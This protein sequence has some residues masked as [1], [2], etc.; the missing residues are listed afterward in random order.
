MAAD[1]DS[2]IQIRRDDLLDAELDK[3]MSN[4]N[5]GVSSSEPSGWIEV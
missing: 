2:E 5:F 3:F 1:A 4:L